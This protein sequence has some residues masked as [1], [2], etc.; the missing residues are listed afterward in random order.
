[1]PACSYLGLGSNMGDSNQ[2]I[3]QAIQ[4]ISEIDNIEVTKKASFYLSKAWGKTDQNDFV[5]TVI[6][7]QCEL[8][9]EQLLESLQQIE[10]KIGRVTSEKWGPRSIDID[11]LTFA[12]LVVNQPH[13]KIPHPHLTQ[14]SFVLAPLYEINKSLIIA[15]KGHLKNFIDLKAFNREILDKYLL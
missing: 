8:S 9:A 11:I 5:N 1:M 2:N 12:D 14:R 13:L 6:E 4:L 15:N 3:A 10:I 7:I